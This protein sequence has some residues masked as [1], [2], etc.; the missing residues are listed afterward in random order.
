MKPQLLISAAS[1]GS[2]KTLFALG[3]IRSLSRRGLQIQ[4]Y[5]CGTDFMDAQLLTLASDH[6]TVHLDTWL[7]S[8]THLQHM[9]NKYGEKA[10]VCIAEGTAGLF[11]GRNKMQGCSAEMAGL[12]NVPIIL[13][14]NARL[15]GYSVAPLIYGFRHFHSHTPI[16][17]VVFNMVSSEAHYHC[18]REACL[19][20][21]ADCLGYLPVSADLKLPSK[22]TALTLT[23]RKELNNQIDKIAEII[24]K[25]IDINRIL[26]LC[27]RN[28]PCQ[29]TLPYSSDTE[30]DTFTPP[31]RK[32]KIAMARDAAFNFTHRENIEQL[33]RIGNITCFSPVYGSELPEA[34]LVYLPGGYPELFARQLHRRHKLMEDLRNYAERGGRILAEGGGMLFLSRSLTLR[35][36]GTSYPM[37]N[38]LPLDFTM[39]EAKLQSGYRTLLHNGKEWRG[40]EYQY[41]RYADKSVQAPLFRHKNVI[42]SSKHL[43]WGETDLLKL[44]E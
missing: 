40:N 5:K 27:N 42:A 17:G 22:H 19:D 12:L 26:N 38:L 41:F 34:D 39:E 37:A 15:T 25:Q 10:D 14:V 1:S 35:Q 43:Y 18:L 23:A 36:G 44:W 24:E 7:A 28:F 3:L 29:Y 11:D 4:P 33:K 30:F 16:A 31:A 13:L 32:I 20:A 8:Y 21:G 6:E 2:G 9:Y